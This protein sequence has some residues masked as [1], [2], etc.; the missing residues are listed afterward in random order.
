MKFI[1]NKHLFLFLNKILLKFLYLKVII[2]K[3]KK[4][5]YNIQDF[6][7]KTDKCLNELINSYFFVQNADFK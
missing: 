5:T 7:Q 3:L 1:L 2:K 4:V 6:D